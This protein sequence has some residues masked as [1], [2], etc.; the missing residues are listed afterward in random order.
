MGGIERS[1]TT[2]S[3]EFVKKGY[4]VHFISCLSGDHFYEIN[5]EIKFY[6]P[7][8][9]RR[10]TQ[11]NKIYYYSKLVFFLRK[12]IKFIKPDKIL[13]FGDWFNPLV[14]LSTIGTNNQVFISDRTIPGFKLSFPIFELKKLLYPKSKGFIAQTHQAKAFNQKLFRNK[15][16]IEV[17][18][19]ALPEFVSLSNTKTH[20]RENKILYLGRFSREKDPEILIKAMAIIAPKFPDWTLEMAGNGVL[21]NSMKQITK[22]LSLE[23]NIK[24]IGK[25]KDVAVQYLS[26]SILVLPSKVEGFPNS[27]IEG[28]AFGLPC[29]CFDDIP[30]E[31]IITHNYN[32]IVLHNR[33]EIEL[34]NQLE[35]LM[36]NKEWRTELGKNAALSINR[37][38]K[39]EIAN[40]FLKF[41]F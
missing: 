14:L 7:S 10:Q 21:L 24:F 41:I 36:V 39:D 6:E 2:L 29:I 30:F 11:I 25:V 3:G 18:P 34:A 1:L 28:M 27:L 12:T 20:K 26:G 4:D 35:K 13:A 23:N 19:N 33:S 9:K 40:R 15:L 16:N 32:G 38:S 31:E 37:F 22:E 5:P 8:F 17:I